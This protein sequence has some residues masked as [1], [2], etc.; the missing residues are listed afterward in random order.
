[1]V[2]FCLVQHVCKLSADEWTELALIVSLFRRCF[3]RVLLQISCF[4][5]DFAL[6]LRARL[7][8]TR[9]CVANENICALAP[10]RT[11]SE[12]PPRSNVGL[13]ENER[14]DIAALP[15]I[16][17][18]IIW[19]ASFC[20]PN[21]ALMPVPAVCERKRWKNA[22]LARCVTAQRRISADSM[23]STAKRRFAA[24]D[25]KTCQKCHKIKCKSEMMWWCRVIKMTQ[26]TPWKYVIQNITIKHLLRR[27]FYCAS[28]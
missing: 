15:T 7:K 27:G 6:E 21:A 28:V 19:N 2:Q 18:I 3:G 8:C 12:P 14:L 23:K 1:M 24:S 17:T 20:C 25:F 9:R 22:I 26:K 16:P 5:S 13:I 11:N 10:T 4:L